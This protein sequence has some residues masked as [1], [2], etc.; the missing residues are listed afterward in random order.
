[1]KEHEATLPQQWFTSLSAANEI[2]TI[3]IEQGSIS[4]SK[5]SAAKIEKNRS[6]ESQRREAY[7]VFIFTLHG[8]YVEVSGS[9]APIERNGSDSCDSDSSES[10]GSDSDDRVLSMISHTPLTSAELLKE[11]LFLQKM[12]RNQSTLEDPPEIVIGTQVTTTKTVTIAESL[13][14]KVLRSRQDERHDR[15]V[16]LETAIRVD[17]KE[18]PS[19][20]TSAKALDISDEKQETLPSS[21]SELEKRIS[22]MTT[23][24]HEMAVHQPKLDELHGSAAEVAE[25]AAEEQLL[26]RFGDMFNCDENLQN[27]VDE[28]KWSTDTAK[29]ARRRS[30]IS[31]NL[32]RAMQAEEIS[33]TRDQID[34]GKCP[35]TFEDYENTA[36]YIEQLM[37]DIDNHATQQQALQDTAEADRKQAVMAQLVASWQ[38]TQH[39]VNKAATLQRVREIEQKR[40]SQWL[41]SQHVQARG[42]SN[43]VQVST[44][45][46]L[47]RRVQPPLPEHFTGNAVL[48]ALSNHPVQ[49]L[50]SASSGPNANS[51]HAIARRVRESIAK[52]DDAYIR[53]TLSLLAAH[54]DPDTLQPAVHFSSGPDILFSSWRGL[55]M[56]DINFGSRPA[57][58]GP[59][60]LQHTDGVVIFLDQVDNQPGLNALVF[61]ELE[62][63]HKLIELWRQHVEVAAFAHTLPGA[64]GTARFDLT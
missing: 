50:D 28:E 59:P 19:H 9:A 20:S 37:I 12:R 23:F 44:A 45:V 51:L 18:R 35:W 39:R 27:A 58:A 14:I 38:Y 26:K 40:R 5:N 22:L 15:F 13:R 25:A 57:Y 33:G 42:H 10:E 17:C 56:A 49:D 60:T 36:Q 48:P 3:V 29:V 32:P 62:A 61:L 63:M 34:E 11:L 21:S 47:R 55:G 1:M 64:P 41:Q 53:D 16:E 7:H 8:I 52:F 6:D 31:T 54:P 43:A 30:S 24:F 2:K 4:I 46:N